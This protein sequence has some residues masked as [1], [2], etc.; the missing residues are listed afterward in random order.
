MQFIIASHGKMASG[1]QN[2]LEMLIGECENIHVLDAYLDDSNPQT[3]LDEMVNKRFGQEDIVIM[4]DLYGGSIN[5]FATLLV[6]DRVRLVTGINLALVM[7]LIYLKEITDEEIEQA[8]N[9]SKGEIRQ[10]KM[11]DLKPKDDEEF[12]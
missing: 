6:S 7:E 11:N 12:F 5:R 9:I 3:V 10:I 4:T 2:S 8:I 1:I